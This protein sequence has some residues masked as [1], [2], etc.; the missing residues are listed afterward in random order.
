MT[1]EI[2]VGKIARVLGGG[3]HTRA[4]AA[5]ISTDR[6]LA[7]IVQQVVAEVRR[8]ARPA[9]SIAQIMSTGRPQT[10]SPELTVAEASKLMSRY[11]HE[12][13]PV[14]E[15]DPS[16]REV[17]LG[18]LTRR[19]A[20][21]AIS[22]KM[23]DQP[24]AR[25]MRAGSVTISPRASI[26]E[27]RKLM[28]QT[29]WG[30]IPVLDDTGKIIGIVTRTDLIKLWDGA[31]LPE[32]HAPAVAEK[33]Q[34]VLLPT[35]LAL[36]RRVGT[37][38]ERLKFSVYIVGGFVRDLLL[39]HNSEPLA[40][41]DM[42][43]VIEGDAIAF[44]EHWSGL[45]GG[46]VV[47]HRRFNTAK[48]ILDDTDAPV[49]TNRLALDL[50]IAPDALRLGDH[51]DFVSARTEFYNA[52][53]ALPTVEDS[54]IKLDLHRRDFTINTLA[55]CLNPPRWG[56]LM[57]FYGGLKD[58]D[59]R[60]V[61]VLHSLSFVDDPTRIMRA[62]R[63]EQR[64]GFQIEPRTLELL[65]DAVELLPRMTPARLRHEFERIFQEKYPE[66]SLVRLDELGILRAIHPALAFDSATSAQIASVRSAYTDSDS[67]DTLRH[68]TLADLYWGTLAYRL[69]QDQATELADRLGLQNAT[70]QVI[71]GIVELR[72]RESALQDPH[73]PASQ[74]AEM[75]DSLSPASLLLGRVLYASKPLIRGL[76]DSYLKQ[77]RHVR[78]ELDG[79]DLAQ[80]GIPQGPV[81][82]TILTAL[83]N[84]KLN[85][86]VATRAEEEE[87]ALEILRVETTGP[88]SDQ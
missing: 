12:G 85:G 4:A 20:D 55:I 86:E 88:A 52:P 27:L 60:K 3:G 64:F 42:D 78:P 57:D 83:R 15:R 14:I 41:K 23:G 25:F 80:M 33:L 31:A 82:R 22:H 19:E 44:A 66:R 76:I 35:D 51:L 81:Y 48:W 26:G 71:A 30:Q 36:L 56:E 8:H 59:E 50:G 1:D 46:R 7:E 5:P 75:M 2:D 17:V 49:K 16:G 70:Q 62:V 47:P 45:Y 63:Y 74:V 73:I 39:N 58:L 11:G 79:N 65:H 34:R 69:S 53:T 68:S 84:A 9:I 18:V 72:A 40:A 6:P 54:S 87:L 77:W 38:V 13:F 67:T 21:R 37:E 24:V 29:N 61:R 32:S 43:I 28:T 10:L